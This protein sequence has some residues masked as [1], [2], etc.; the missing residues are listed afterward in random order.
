MTPLT[1][2]TCEFCKIHEDKLL[3]EDEEHILH[4]CPLGSHI[5]ERFLLRTSQYSTG[6]DFNLATVFK[7]DF[8]NDQNIT[9]DISKKIIRLSTRT[10]RDIYNATIKHKESLKKAAAIPD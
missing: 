7:A 10:I 9:S 4:I 3:I 6:V 2:R 8:S 5:R 1:S